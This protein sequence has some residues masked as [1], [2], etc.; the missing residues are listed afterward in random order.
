M[1]TNIS[2]ESGRG[3]TMIQARPQREDTPE[4][5]DTGQR[6]LSESVRARSQRLEHY[7]PKAS[8]STTRGC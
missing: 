7:L 6:A 8:E 3:Q 4:T 1:V 5:I 2:I